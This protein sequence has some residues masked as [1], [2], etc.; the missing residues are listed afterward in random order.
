MSERDITEQDRA[1]LGTVMETETR[2]VVGLR[3]GT[4]WSRAASPQ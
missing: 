1:L 4:R 3:T 2:L